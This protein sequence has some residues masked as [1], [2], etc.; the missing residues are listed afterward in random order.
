MFLAAAFCIWFVR[1]W[2][3]KEIR[4]LNDEGQKASVNSAG[5]DAPLWRVP[6]HEEELKTRLDE[7][8]WRMTCIEKLQE[9]AR[10]QRV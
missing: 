9:F 2:K 7:R 1:A 8:S 5:G 6:A 10:W 4:E 3:I